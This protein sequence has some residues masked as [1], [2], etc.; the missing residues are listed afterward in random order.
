MFGPQNAH[1]EATEFETLSPEIMNE[2]LKYLLL[3][4]GTMYPYQAHGARRRTLRLLC[5]QDESLRMTKEKKRSR[6]SDEKSTLV[7]HRCK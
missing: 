3:E 4:V 2:I 6:R 7:L 1:P 5:K